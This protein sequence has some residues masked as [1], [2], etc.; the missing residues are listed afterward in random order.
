MAQYYGVNRS[1]DYL[2]H[3]GVK[4]MK[5]GVRKAIERHDNAA[6]LR[7]YSKAQKK[8]KTL[9]EHTNRKAQKEEAI[10][11]AATGALGIGA[12]A[13]GGLA[14]YGVVKGQLAAQ[15][16][17]FPNDEYRMIMHPIGLYGMT[18][19]ALGG[20]LGLL[21]ASIPAAYR[22]TKM[23]NKHAVKKYNKFKSEMNK[24]FS[25]SMLNKIHKEE[26]E[27]Y[28]NDLKNQYKHEDPE[29]R[30]ML[31]RQIKVAEQDL[32]RNN[33]PRKKKSHA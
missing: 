12:G 20:G 13:L 9:K 14:S 10:G 21:G 6:Y 26:G 1:D 33:K 29:T 16:A 7:Q 8:L 31:A 22:A 23:G 27:K 17:L 24:T 2:A 3:Y 30:K 32:Y 15:R 5:W 25:K 19:A 28:L 18:G 4:G 11:R